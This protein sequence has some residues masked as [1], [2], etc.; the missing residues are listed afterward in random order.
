MTLAVA[1]IPLLVMRYGYQ[2]RQRSI[3]TKDA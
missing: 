1:P 3:Y 2:W